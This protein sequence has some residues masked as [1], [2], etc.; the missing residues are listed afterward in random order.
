MGEV[1]NIMNEI[2][3]NIKLRPIR[4]IFLVKPN[5]KKNILKIF[6]INTLLWGGK[7]NPIIPFFKRVPKWWS[8]HYKAYNAKQILN[9]YLDFFEPDFIVEAEEGLADD[10]IFDKE[11]ILQLDNLLKEDEYDANK[12]GLNI[13]DLYLH[14]YEK[15]YQFERKHKL[16]IIN[17]KAKEKYLQPLIFC[18]FG[19][20]INNEEEFSY[21]ERNYLD[22]FEPNEIELNAK[23]LAEIYKSQYFAPIDIGHIKIDIQY[24]NTPKKAD[25]FL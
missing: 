18:I 21:F 11:R 6:Q 10:I 17:V 16:S 24:Y 22:I 5:D 8:T 14:L 15:K 13:N 12:Y 7:F 19:S 23:S 25:N 1:R 4:F 3:L 20:F 2:K 9:N